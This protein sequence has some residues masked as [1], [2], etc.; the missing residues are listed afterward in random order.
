M[1][2]LSC[3]VADIAVLAAAPVAAGGAGA[4]AAGAGAAAGT[5]TMGGTAWGN[6]TRNSLQWAPSSGHA[7]ICQHPFNIISMSAQQPV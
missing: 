1:A 4:G 2:M 7:V 5:G 6:C 3:L